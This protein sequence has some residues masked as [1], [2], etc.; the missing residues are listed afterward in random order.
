MDE[1]IVNSALKTYFGYTD[2][3][4]YQKAVIDRTFAGKNSLVIMNT[5]GGKSLI[6]QLPAVL[7][8][9]LTVVVS[10]LL[11]LMRDQVLSLTNNGIP[12]AALNSECSDKEAREIITAVEQGTVK[13]LYVSPERAVT[14]QFMDWLTRQPVSQLA[15]DE[16][17][18]VSIWGN[19]FRPEYTKLSGLVRL[20]PGVPVVA[21]TATADKATQTEILSQL[22]LGVCETFISSFERKNIHISVYPARDRMGA[23]HTFLRA[24]TADSGIIYC[25]SRNGAEEVAA[26]LRQMG[27]KARHFHAKMSTEEKRQVQDAFQSDEIQIICATI[28]FGLGIDK[29]NIRWVLHFNLPK[30]IEAYYQEIGRA[31]RDGNPAEAVLFAG[32]NDLNTYLGFLE[33]SPGSEIYK[34]VQ[35]E[36]LDRMWEFAKSQACRTNFILNYFGE[37][38][39]KPCGHCDCCLN[40]PV[41][42]DA[43][44]IAQKALSACLRLNQDV[45]MTMLV[46]V[47]RG[48]SHQEIMANGYHTIKT[49]GAGKEFSWKHWINY[50]TQLVDRGLLAIDYSRGSKLSLTNLSYPVLK[51]ET[52][53]RLCEFQ[54][55]PK[56]LESKRLPKSKQSFDDRIYASLVA[57]RKQIAEEQ[58]VQVFVIFSNASLEDMAKKLPTTLDAFNLISGVGE[59]KLNWYGE[60][61]VSAIKEALETYPDAVIQ[62]SEPAK[63][64]STGK[65]GASNRLE[66]LSLLNSGLSI[67]ETAK[68]CGLAQSTIVDH[69]IRLKE[70]GHPV[71][72][73]AFIN[74]DEINQVQT[75]WHTLGKP[76]ELKPVY[77]G[78]NCAMDYLKIKLALSFN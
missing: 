29:P 22:Q 68:Q 9:G 19:D 45:G 50:L 13:L 65:K 53:V 59:K 70:E 67:E 58:G 52:T 41:T 6:Y 61:F 11:A 21:L 64:V 12:A 37:Y 33:K 31:G 66:T 1:N 40:P 47:L 32:Y 44:V 55:N 78:L 73:N 51:G 43:T 2:F 74:A 48:S 30:N 60:R 38:T 26:K 25:L 39:E 71:D 5:G 54:N 34:G 76:K 10:P 69:V 56:G 4:L 28:A 23:I 46:N 17:H 62:A 72:I 20:L 36:K 18:C 75:M 15:I 63:K 7:L 14:G 57:L 16:A 27:Y 8:K 77:E 3:R 49:Y 42:F 24:R 35:R